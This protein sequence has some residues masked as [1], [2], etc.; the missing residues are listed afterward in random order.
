MIKSKNTKNLYDIFLLKLKTCI[1]AAL[2]SFL[3]N[4]GLQFLEF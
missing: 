1:D 4:S 3:K 2:A